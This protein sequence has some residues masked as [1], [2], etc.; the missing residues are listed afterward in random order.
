VPAARPRDRPRAEASK[1]GE[2]ERRPLHHELVAGEAPRSAE[3]R[4]LQ[5]GAASFH[6]DTD[7]PGYSVVN[8]VVDVAQ[9]NRQITMGQY[10]HLL[11]LLKRIVVSFHERRVNRHGARSKERRDTVVTAAAADVWA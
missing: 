8:L 5:R 7:A 2:K 3:L 4:T 6:L 9:K 11:A 10:E 1:E